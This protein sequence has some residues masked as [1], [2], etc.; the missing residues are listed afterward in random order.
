MVETQGFTPDSK[1]S[2]ALRIP[3]ESGVMPIS[4]PG[5]DAREFQQALGA[6]LLKFPDEF[7]ALAG[8]PD[9]WRAAAVDH[10]GVAG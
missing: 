3:A 10:K 9:N 6:G 5:D 2:L 8:F 7:R 4:E 1:A